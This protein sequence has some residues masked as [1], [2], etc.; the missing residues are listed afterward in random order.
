MSFGP[1]KLYDEKGLPPTLYHYTSQKGLVGIISTKSIWA[2]DIFF[3]NDASEFQYSENI[4]ANEIDNYLKTAKFKE[5]ESK[6]LN[7]LPDVT[8][9]VREVYKPFVCSFSEESDL[10]SQWRGYC[11][12]VS[13]FSIGFDTKIMMENLKKHSFEIS[14]CNYKIEEQK[15]IILKLIKEFVIGFRKIENKNIEKVTELALKFQSA[16]YGNVPRLKDQ[17]FKEEKEWRFVL[18]VR[19]VKFYKPDEINFREGKS[20]LIPYMS[21][22]LW[23]ENEKIPIKEIIIGPTP[24]MD[25][26]QRALE[27]FLLKNH[28]IATEIKHSK[29]P[30]RNL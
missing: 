20:M 17:S 7:L 15:L 28:V 24:H 3:L 1:I 18:S 8:K 16:F 11:S 4:L 21:V 9:S 26:S 25:L 12:Q 6:L 22:P 2:T 27:T 19:T 13:G 29:I 14:Q 5:D 30:F 23:Q 10:L